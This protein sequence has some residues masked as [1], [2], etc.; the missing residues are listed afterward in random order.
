MSSLFIATKVHIPPPRPDLI[1]RPRLI[2]RLEAGLDRKL[3]ML[4]A[5]AGF[6]KSSLLSAWVAGCARP[7][8]WLSLDERDADPMRFLYHLIAALQTIE[9][10]I[11]QTALSALRSFA[12]VSLASG[13][14]N[15]TAQQTA[16]VPCKNAAP[17]H[18]ITSAARPTPSSP[19]ALGEPCVAAARAERR[20]GAT[21]PAPTRS[22]SDRWP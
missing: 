1:D 15:G 3:T 4:S 7:A 14:V 5:P 12:H 19:A 17:R 11:G 13:K 20:R 6:G 9:T 21:P 2:K 18:A 22:R 8:A 16:R 10:S